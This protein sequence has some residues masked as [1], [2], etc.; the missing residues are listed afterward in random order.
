MSLANCKLLYLSVSILVKW[1]SAVLLQ[2]RGGA[3]SKGGSATEVGRTT[4]SYVLI[5]LSLFQGH[6]DLE[7]CLH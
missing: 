3:V 5:M 6:Q 4:E 7:V 2:R 1:W